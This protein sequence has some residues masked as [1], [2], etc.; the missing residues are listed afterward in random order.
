MAPAPPELRGTIEHLGENI[1]APS[2]WKKWCV[3]NSLR[4]P[5]KAVAGLGWPARAF[6]LE[7]QRNNPP[8]CQPL[9]EL[10]R[11]RRQVKVD[12][13]CRPPLV[14]RASWLCHDCGNPPMIPR[15]PVLASSNKKTKIGIVGERS[16]DDR[17]AGSRV[18]R[19]L[20]RTRHPSV[21]DSFLL[22]SGAAS[23]CTPSSTL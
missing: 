8:Y 15:C 1:D 13:C 18:C 5:L 23:G 7:A 22:A 11:S 20:T 21:R 14:M 9:Y 12:T 19:L 3:Q 2:G 6:N 4:G 17:N 10:S 16:R